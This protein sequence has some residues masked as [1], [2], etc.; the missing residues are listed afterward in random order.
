MFNLPNFGRVIQQALEAIPNDQREGGLIPGASRWRDSPFTCC[1]PK[2]ALPIATPAS[3]CRRV[4]RSRE[5][6]AL[7]YTA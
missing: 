5:A 1:L 2:A 6:A 3:F 4:V 7:I